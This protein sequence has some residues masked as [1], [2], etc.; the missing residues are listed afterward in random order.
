MNNI[1][2]IKIYEQDRGVIHITLQP[3]KT[4]TITSSLDWPTT[5][6]LCS[7]FFFLSPTICLDCHFWLPFSQF[8]LL[9]PC[10][11]VPNSSRH[12]SMTSSHILGSILPSVV[13]LATLMVIYTTFHQIIYPQNIKRKVPISPDHSP[14]THPWV[15]LSLVLAVLLVQLEFLPMPLLLML[16]VLLLALLLLLFC[17]LFEMKVQI[18]VRQQLCLGIISC[19]YR[20]LLYRDRWFSWFVWWTLSS[21]YKLVGLVDWSTGKPTAPP[22]LHR[23]LAEHWH[24]FRLMVGDHISFVFSF[25]TRPLFV[26][27][28]FLERLPL[29]SNFFQWYLSVELL[30]LV[31]IFW[32]CCQSR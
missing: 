9:F 27:H 2:S 25:P 31:R 5:T 3:R 12:L 29:T 16:W 15:N 6:I 13:N 20:V 11:D 24:E 30:M 28:S 32:I 7:L 21:C 4:L 1:T 18:L 8:P 17:H 19:S 26:G 23:A 22:F 10:S 14:L